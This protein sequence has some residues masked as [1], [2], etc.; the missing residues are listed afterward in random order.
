VH[1]N[2]PSKDSTEHCTK[3]FYKTRKL[4]KKQNITAQ[5][6]ELKGRKEK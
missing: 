1:R 2:E 3:A 6:I 5:F 4:N